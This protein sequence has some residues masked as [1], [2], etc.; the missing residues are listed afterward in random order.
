MIIESH[1]LKKKSPLGCIIS[2]NGKIKD[3]IRFKTIGCDS[4]VPHYIGDGWCDD[5]NNNDDCNFD[6]G[7]CC[8]DPINADYC[9]E[10]I[11]YE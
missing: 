7:D 8:L 1:F 5:E 4:D 6:G 3:S 10:C 11:C 9:T 2:F